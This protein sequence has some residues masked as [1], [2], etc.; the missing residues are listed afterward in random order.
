MAGVVAMMTLGTLDLVHHYGTAP[1]A[2]FALS[3]VRAV[4]VLLY[5]WWPRESWWLAVAAAVGTALVTTPVSPSEPWPWAV[6]SVGLLVG[7]AG[8]LSARGSRRETGLALA[9]LTGLG[10]LLAVVRGLPEGWWVS[11]VT[12]TA[13]CGVGAVLGDLALGQLRVAA[14]L[15]QEQRVSAAERARRAVVE[16]RTRIARELH[17]VVAHHM[18]MITVQAETARYRLPGLPEPAAEEFAGIA[19]LARGSLAELRGL[20]SALRD[21]ADGPVFAPQPTLADLDALAQR[22]T[23]A[24]TPVRLRVSGETDGLPSV[25]QLSAYRVVQEALSNVVRH[26]AGA[27]T[28]VT[29]TVSDAVDAVNVEVANARPAQPSSAAPGGHGLTGLRERVTLLGGTFEIDQPN[30]G[31]RVRVRLPVKEEP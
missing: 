23:A 2:A 21:S 8:V 13:L 26:A 10:A 9:V 24:G 28:T 6:G 31:W 14:A 12:T 4:P 19:R 20:L 15:A 7:M 22:I 16:E 17:D 18:S 25:V 1:P 5:R 30:G 3:A 29:V 11:V 27:E